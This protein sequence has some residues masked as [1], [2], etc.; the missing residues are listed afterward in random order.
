VLLLVR[1]LPSIPV[2][3]PLAATRAWTLALRPWGG[4]ILRPLVE[5]IGRLRG[6]ARGA[7]RPDPTDDPDDGEE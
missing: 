4:T 3:L 5:G 7:R 6:V 1:R 2:L